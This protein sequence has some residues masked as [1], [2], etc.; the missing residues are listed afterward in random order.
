VA[1]VTANGLTRP[2]LQTVSEPS[3]GIPA[4]PISS[5][6]FAPFETKGEDAQANSMYLLANHHHVGSGCAPCPVVATAA[7]LLDRIALRPTRERL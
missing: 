3:Q 2:T 6:R 4:E 5:R 1:L 7:R